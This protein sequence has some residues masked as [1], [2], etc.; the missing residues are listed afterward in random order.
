[1]KMGSGVYINYFSEYSKKD[2][3]ILFNEANDIRQK[4]IIEADGICSKY[5]S[6]DPESSDSKQIA[7]DLEDLLLKIAPYGLQVLVKTT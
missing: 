2:I 4:D 3:F 7:D 6:E 5:F 1:M